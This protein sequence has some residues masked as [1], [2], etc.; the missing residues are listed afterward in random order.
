MISICSSVSLIS[1]THHLTKPSCLQI[2]RI[3]AN[4]A[5]KKKEFCVQL[6]RLG[7]LTALCATLKMADQE[8]VTLSLDVLFML[9]VSSTQVSKAT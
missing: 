7:L 4:I 8:M 9:V 1:L 2:L 5:H 6:A 3:L